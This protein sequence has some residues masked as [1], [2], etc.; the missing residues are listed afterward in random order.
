MTILD[1]VDRYYIK[2]P[3]FRKFVSTILYGNKNIPIQFFGTSLYIN[4]VKEN[5][6]FRASKH[7]KKNIVFRDELTVL[8]NLSGLVSGNSTFVDVGANVGLFSSTLGRFKK[9]YPS[10]LIYAFEANPDTYNRLVESVKNLSVNTF[11]LAISNKDTE[12]E[13][14]EGAVS[15][16]FAEKSHANTYHYKNSKITKIKAKRLDQLDISGNSI[17]LKID[18]EGH[19]YEVLEGAIG[20][21]EE[22]RIKA[23][24]LDGYQNQE[25]VISLL[26]KY[27]FTFFNGRTLTEKEKD[28][29]SL[30]ALRQN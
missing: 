27:N 6:Y 30:L 24:Y 23:V 25:K 9:I 18:V 13:F 21:F 19:E 26:T 11:N 2:K 5:G 4:T 22:N 1:L 17:I 10:F 14:V 20:L 28:N 12:L 29:F 3:R 7:S 8:L 15:G 16:V